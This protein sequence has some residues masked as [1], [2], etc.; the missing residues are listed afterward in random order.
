MNTWQI[1]RA[2]RSC[3]VTA[4]IFRG[5]FAA[6]QLPSPS[7]ELPA[8]YIANCS[9]STSGGT[10]WVA[11]YQDRP[12]YMKT[13]DSYGRPLSSYNPHLQSLTE[14]LKIIQQCQI[15]QQ[16]ASTTCGQ[17]ALMFVLKRADKLS[18]RDFIHL[19]TDNTRSNDKMV[20][21][22]VNSC[23]D[24]ETRVYNTALIKQIAREFVQ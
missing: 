24:L 8:A 3:P 21:Q 15:L 13:F 7:Q 22:F 9:D 16:P 20:C 4:P 18:Y 5:V 1:D 12:G 10:H 19:F 2:M 23:F 11:F 17:Y 14:G 6:D